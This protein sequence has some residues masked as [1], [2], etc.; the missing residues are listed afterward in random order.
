MVRTGTRRIPAWWG[1]TGTG[2]RVYGGAG[3]VPP[4]HDA[5]PFLRCA[6]VPP[7]FPEL[8]GYVKTSAGTVVPAGFGEREKKSDRI[9]QQLLRNSRRPPPLPRGPRPSPGSESWIWLR[10]FLNC[11]SRRMVDGGGQ[12][13][14][15]H[16]TRA[17]LEIFGGACDGMERGR[18][19]SRMEAEE[20]THTH[21]SR[22]KQR[23]PTGMGGERE[24]GRLWCSALQAWSS[25][26]RGWIYWE[27]SF[28]QSI[29]HA[30]AGE[31]TVES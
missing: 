7:L 3:L 8:A 15:A 18:S 14:R 4:E 20:A 26:R 25:I 30:C 29:T 31:E 11:F 23:T 1:A 24:R 16:T 22:K 5:T 12:D 2:R 28:L 27:S 10:D 17:D 19:F 21:L 6:T 13:G 9:G